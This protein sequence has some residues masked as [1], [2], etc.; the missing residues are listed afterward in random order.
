MILL[1]FAKKIKG[2]SSV[3]GHIDWITID[4]YQ[5]GVGRAISSV[6]GGADRDT[7]NPS[8]SEM[9]LSKST[10]IASSDLFMEASC[11]KSL[12]TAELHFIQTG[13]ADQTQQVYLTIELH[14]AVV[15][16]YSSSSNGERPLETI[17]LNFTKIS[18]KYDAFS[19]DKITTGTV[20]TWD[21]LNNKKV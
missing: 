10:D 6:G 11:G 19:G 16:S 13:G 15:S 12:G 17:S 9:T 1:N 14:E 21:L 8:F 4:A 20:K 2:T 18:Y 3:D 5:W 7:S